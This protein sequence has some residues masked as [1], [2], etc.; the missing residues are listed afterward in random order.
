M[1]LYLIPTTGQWLGTQADAARGARDAGCKF[2]QIDVPTDKAGLMEFLTMHAV[3]QL[4]EL[5]DRGG[6]IERPVPAAPS[7]AI[8]ARD[9][10]HPLATM[11]IEDWCEAAQPH[12]LGTVMRAASLRLQQISQQV[13]R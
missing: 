8:E 9:A 5:P 11:A 6:D 12:Q 13:A 3:G 7:P 1:K 4:A 2:E 10:R